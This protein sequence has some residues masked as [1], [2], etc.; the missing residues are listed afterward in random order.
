MLFVSAR[1]FP[2]RVG[3][4]LVA[5]LGTGQADPAYS[6]GGREVRVSVLRAKAIDGGA[7]R[8][9]DQRLLGAINRR[10]DH[11]AQ[12]VFPSRTEDVFIQFAPKKL[13]GGVGE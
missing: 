11:G 9:M 7:V 12:F 3:H 8:R 10:I 13:R 1:N 6:V 5:E 4:L 2:R